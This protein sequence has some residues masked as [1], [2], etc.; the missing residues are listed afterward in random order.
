MKP[1]SGP[2][3]PR[4]GGSGHR[5]RGS[6]SPCNRDRSAERHKEARASRGACVRDIG[7]GMAEFISTQPAVLAHAMHDRLTQQAQA[8]KKADPPTRARW[9]RFG[10]TWSR[11]CSSPRRPSVETGARFSD[12][13]GGL[14]AIRGIVNVTV[15]A[16]ALAG[17]TDEP[18][19]LVGRCPIDPDTARQLAGHASGWDRVLADPITGCVLAVDRYTPVGGYET[20]PAG[21]G[22]ALP[23]PRLPATRAPVRSGPHPRLRIGR[24]NRRLQPRVPLQKTPHVERRNRLD[25]PPTRRRSP[26]MDVP[27]RAGLHRQT[28]LGDP[29]HP[30]HRPTPVLSAVARSLSEARRAE[31]E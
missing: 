25:G 9:I 16:L 4:P 7:D 12:G 24:R 22:S 13:V 27:R 5:S 28:T 20:V 1:W 2:R 15:P 31:T 14:G 10:R 3:A 6:R 29:L 19:E 8:L 26:R 23:V 11:T 18:A 21:A 17:V 30:E